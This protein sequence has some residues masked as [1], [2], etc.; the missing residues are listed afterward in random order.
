MQ[1]A[2]GRYHRPMA[3]ELSVVIPLYDEARRIALGLDGLDWLRRLHPGPVEAI[4]VDDGSRD[5]SLALARAAEGPDTRVLA[6]PHQGKGAALAAGVMEARADRILLVDVDWSVPPPQALLLLEHDADLVL[7]TR[8]GQGAHRLGEPPW[9]HLLGRAFNRYVQWLI[10]AGHED[11]QCGCKLLRRA[12][13]HDLFPLLQVA[14]WAYD[15][16]LV[17]VA[18]HRGWTVAEQPVAWRYEADS[19]LRPGV[20]ALAMAREVWGV[21]RRIRQ[22]S[23]GPG[24]SRRL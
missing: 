16:E 19:R 12:A 14:G 23:Y 6:R 11:T 17:A 5:D 8:E 9:R 21:A 20:D 3:P 1:D 2:D 4:L 24:G 22:G 13:A 18:H 10:L 15:V 7:A